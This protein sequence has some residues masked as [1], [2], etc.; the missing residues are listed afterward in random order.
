MNLSNDPVKL[1]SRNEVIQIV[2]KQV[3]KLKEAN[4][5]QKQRINDFLEYLDSVELTND[6]IRWDQ[7]RHTKHG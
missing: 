1:Y 2:D 7:E 4:E 3:E 5:R 6:F